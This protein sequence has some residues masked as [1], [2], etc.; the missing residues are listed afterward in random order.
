MTTFI[1]NTRVTIYNN[2][3]TED[4]MGM[5]DLGEVVAEHVPASLTEQSS[6]IRGDNS[7]T[8]I[9][10]STVLG[11]VP[12][13]TEVFSDYKLKDERND[14]FYVVDRMTD[15]RNPAGTMPKRLQLRRLDIS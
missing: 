10:V 2:T 3:T 14:V 6:D 5:S 9:Q 15:Y 1:A 4:D 11:I 8:N 12:F 13:G 7:S